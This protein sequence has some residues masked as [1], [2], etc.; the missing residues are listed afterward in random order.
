MA[1]GIRT[2]LDP[3]LQFASVVGSEGRLAPG[4]DVKSPVP[5]QVCQLDVVG[6][7]FPNDVQLPFAYALAGVLEPD[8]S[9]GPEPVRNH[10]VLVAIAIDFAHRHTATPATLP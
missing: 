10:D 4:D 7:W 2:L 8:D 9:L 3:N 6:L 5:V 1:P